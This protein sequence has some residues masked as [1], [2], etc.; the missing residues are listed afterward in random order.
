MRPDLSGLL[1]ERG[2]DIQTKVLKLSGFVFVPVAALFLSRSGHSKIAQHFS[3]G[4]TILLVLLSPI[5]DDR[6]HGCPSSLTGL[7]G[8]SLLF[9]STEVLGYF[10]SVPGGTQ[11]P[12][13]LSS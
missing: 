8:S 10:R 3:A 13:S 5:R 2:D 1:K 4:L 12:L 11:K 6:R 9:P 7:C